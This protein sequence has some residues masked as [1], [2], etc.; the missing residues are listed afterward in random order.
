M[1]KFPLYK[2]FIPQTL[3]EEELDLCPGRH[4]QLLCQDFWEVSITHTEVKLD[5]TQPFLS[6]VDVPKHVCPAQDFL[7]L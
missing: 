4:L 7:K 6:M 5:S 3:S 1:P 2:V